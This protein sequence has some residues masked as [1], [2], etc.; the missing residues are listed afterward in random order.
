M[1]DRKP[2]PPFASDA[3][4][5]DLV[6]LFESCE[7]PGTRWTHRAHLAVAASY[8]RC[9]PLSGATDRARVHIR[10]YNESRGNHTGYH[11]TVTVLFLRLVA[12]ELRSDPP[13]LSAFVN[14]LAGRFPTDW[15]LGYY[16]RDRL[17]SAE[18]RA[19]FLEPDLRPL[20]F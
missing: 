3:E 15:L 10:R 16:S 19:G 14:D 12:R 5:A 4:V 2:D 6:R 1:A 9:Y 7:L 17:W 13:T 20:D 8:L 18:A 11:E